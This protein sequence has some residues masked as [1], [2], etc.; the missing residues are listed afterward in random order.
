MRFLSIL[1]CLLIATEAVAEVSIRPRGILE[2]QLDRFFTLV[3]DGHLTPEFA[4]T[5]RAVEVAEFRAAAIERVMLNDLDGDGIVSSSEI[6]RA[7]QVVDRYRKPELRALV[8]TVDQNGDGELDAEEIASHVATE[9]D[10]FLRRIHLAPKTAKILEI[11]AMDIDGNGT[12]TSEDIITFFD[13]GRD[14]GA[15]LTFSER[16]HLDMP[17]ADAEIVLLGI[18]RGITLSSVAVNGSKR[19]TTYAELNIT[20]GPKPLYIVALNSANIILKLTGSAHRLERL[21]NLPGLGVIGLDA[22]RLSSITRGGCGFGTFRDTQSRN[23]EAARSVLSGYFGRDIDH[24]IGAFEVM[25]LS[26]PS[27]RDQANEN[28]KQKS[29]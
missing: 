5:V 13:T 20:P 8:A 3:P 1:I 16:C 14:L 19:I 22:T 6:E 15:N 7:G 24:V 27:G 9:V 21:V 17:S 4:E 2:R 11:Q 28:R 18:G 29:G 10:I 12:V 26:L 25:A 23:A